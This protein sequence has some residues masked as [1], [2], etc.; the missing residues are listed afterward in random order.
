MRARLLAIAAA[1]ALAALGLAAPSGAAQFGFKEF[2]LTFRGA[3]PPGTDKFVLGPVQELGAV[4]NQAGSHPYALAVKAEVN[5]KEGPKGGEV[6]VEAVKDLR[7][8][9]MPGLAGIPTA[10]PTCSTVDFLR[11]GKGSNAAGCANSSAVGL[12]RV[13]IGGEEGFEEQEAPVY[14]LDPPPGSVAKLGLWA[15]TVPVTIDIGVKEAPP[16]NVVATSSGV[17]Q[18]LEFFSAETVLW[19]NPAS[20]IHDEERGDCYLPGE[21]LCPATIPEIAFLTAPRACNGPLASR[22]ELDSWENPGAWVAGEALTHDDVGNPQG[23]TG[24]GQLGF[25]PRVNTRPSTDQASSPAG[26]DI[27]LDVEDEGL[28][29]PNGRAAS[30]IKK[31]VVTL[32]EGVTLNPSIAEGLVACSEDDLAKTHANSPPEAGC[33]QASKVGTVEVESPS[34]PG[35]ILG[36]SLF[37]A[38][39][40]QN[41]FGSLIAAYMVIKNADLGVLVTQPI[42]IEPDPKTGQIVSIVDDIPQFPLSH[43]RVHLREGGRSPLISPSSCGTYSTV[44]ELTPWAAP[45][46]TLTSTSDF[47]I[48]R[49][50]GGGPC[51]PAG[52]PPF[53][54]G[55][56]A[57]TINNSA[58]TYS[59]FFTRLTRPDGD[60]D[61]T[62]LSV[63]LPPGVVGK[64]AGVSKCS[65]AQIAAAKAKSGLQ[66]KANPSCPANSQIGTA[67]GGAGVGSQLTYVPGKIYL[68][69]P[70]GG[71]PLSIVGIVPAVAGPF[72]V[73]NV[74]VREALRLN[75][76]TAE[77]EADGS[78]SDPLPYI[79]AGIPLR[80]RDIQVSIDRQDFTLNP[81]SCAPSEAQAKLWGGGTDLFSSADDVPVG[82]A[83]RFQAADCARL[84]FKPSLTMHLKGPTNRG[85]HPALHAVYTPRP[86][87]ANVKETIVRLPRSAFLDQAHI[88]TICTRVQFAAK[89]CPPGAVYGKAKAFT[90]LLD[91]PLTGPVYLRSSNH[92]LPD[93]VAALHGIVDVEAVARIDSKRGG[94]RTSFEDI[95][96]APLTKVVIDLPG[97]KKGL[98]V[99]SRELCAKRS[100]TTAEL[101]AH[102]GRRHDL[103]TP[104]K[105]KCGKSK[106]AGR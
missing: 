99:N 54:P 77:V 42:K 31:T 103:K 52:P 57:G 62:R 53:A 69:G 26:A 17:S 21:A 81:T 106:S 45:N 43:V 55:F 3:P 84:A 94:I 96:D 15:L 50:V 74:V 16:Y 24:C 28:A 102:N 61:V 34:L 35:Q 36:G 80:V 71:A 89:S 79:L 1:T 101:T 66:E 2:D 40:Y 65:E 72:D 41:P 93:F 68:A 59:P 22:W 63:K 95:P 105:V 92:N 39:P 32:P 14:S 46:T 9:N 20:P 8:F 58:G 104:M 30:D 97:G 51:P 90:P 11:R 86:G 38:T 4:E 56:S 5:T 49:G 88:R 47:Q 37:V 23:F 7:V 6:P 25:A 33:P 12:I 18:I 60:Q 13:K 91:E 27:E 85:G 78:V 19:G 87:D 70:I 29:S 44:A 64:L 67:E 83:F 100:F 98:I 75:P 48:T 73:G 82:L 76:R 10:V